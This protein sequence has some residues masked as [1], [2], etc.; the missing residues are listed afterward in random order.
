MNAG[1]MILNPALIMKDGY[2]K[3]LV[4]AKNSIY[5]L[6]NE[7]SC[8]NFL[9]LKT[10]SLPFYCNF[11]YNGPSEDENK[12]IYDGNYHDFL[13]MKYKKIIHFLVPKM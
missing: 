6:Q 12:K 3:K 7:Q 10:K 2:Y 13:K 4:D 1:F 9:P 8:L 11:Y 5:L